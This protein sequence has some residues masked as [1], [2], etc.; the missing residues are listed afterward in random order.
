MTYA[1]DTNTIL[2]VNEND[3][4]EEYPLFWIVRNNNVAMMKVFMDYANS[5]LLTLKMDGENEDGGT[6]LLYAVRHN[7]ID[8]THAIS[9]NWQDKNEKGNSPL[10]A[11]L[12]ENH[13]NNN[14]LIIMN[15]T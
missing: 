13:L 14:G 3:K 8:M 10:L 4:N 7:S 6:P 1:I 5:L 2:N 11:N 9:L 12:T 15:N